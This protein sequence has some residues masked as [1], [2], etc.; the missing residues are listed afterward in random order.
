MVRCD[1]IDKLN[2]HYATNFVPL[3]LMIL[4]QASC[5]DRR[6]LARYELETLR[7][8]QQ[9]CS[10]TIQCKLDSNVA[11]K[12]DIKVATRGVGERGVGQGG[13]G[14]QGGTNA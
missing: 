9:M 3:T 14:G 1:W 4:T 7:N 13:Q 8:W 2:C 5:S 12:N 11:N 10:T 6:M